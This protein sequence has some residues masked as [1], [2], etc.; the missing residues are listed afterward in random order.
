M[1]QYS[2]SISGGQIRFQVGVGGGSWE[3]PL[4]GG[5][6]YP[7]FDLELGRRGNGLDRASDS[8]FAFD[9]PVESA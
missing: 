5:G 1:K 3:I 7:N 6:G 9:W 2:R 4:R 8:V